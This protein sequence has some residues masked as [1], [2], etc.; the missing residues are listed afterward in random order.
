MGRTVF[1][2]LTDDILY[3]HPERILGPVVPFSQ[4]A[5]RRDVESTGSNS[6]TRHFRSKTEV[7]TAESVL[8]P[9]SFK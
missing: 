8:L 4:D 6:E 3:E 5:R 1:I 7:K 2:P 9:A